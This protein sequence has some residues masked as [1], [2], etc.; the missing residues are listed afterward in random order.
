MVEL[1]SRVL[2]AQREVTNRSQSHI[3]EKR[4]SFFAVFMKAVNN[5]TSHGVEF[6]RN[7][8]EGKLVS[9]LEQTS[10]SLSR[11]VKVSILSFCFLLV[12]LCISLESAITGFQFYICKCLYMILLKLTVSFYLYHFFFFMLLIFI[13]SIQILVLYAIQ[14]TLFYYELL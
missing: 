9:Y 4:E 5:S 10:K 6:G 13:D 11:V 1:R 14:L 12:L 8:D 2:S 3:P 7:G